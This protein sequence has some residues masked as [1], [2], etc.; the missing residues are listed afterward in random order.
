[1]HGTRYLP[2]A[3]LSC[4]MQLIEIPSK[5]LGGMTT[6]SFCFILAVYR[7]DRVRV[8]CETCSYGNVAAARN[9][10]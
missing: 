4:T 2:S 6:P 9:G 7:D 1:M 3:K 10:S 5:E 8:T